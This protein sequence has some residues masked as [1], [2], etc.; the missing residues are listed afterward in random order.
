MTGGGPSAATET[1]FLYSYKQ[2]YTMQDYG[3][4]LSLSTL[5]FVIIFILTFIQMQLDRDEDA[6]AARKAARLA[7]RRGKNSAGEGI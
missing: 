6:I 4:A 7:K 3:Y 1:I 2:A 5:S